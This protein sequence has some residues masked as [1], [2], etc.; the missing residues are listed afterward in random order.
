MRGSGTVKCRSSFLRFA[1]EIGAAQ[2]H[3]LGK[4]KASNSGGRGAEPPLRTSQ[5]QRYPIGSRIVLDE[6]NDPY[7]CMPTGLRGV[8][9]GVDN[10]GNIL[11]Q[12]D[13][14]STLNVVPDVDKAHVVACD[15][16][17]KIS[18]E[19]C[20]SQKKTNIFPRC[21]EQITS[22]NRLLALSRRASITI[23]E[24]CGSSEALED[25]GFMKKKPIAEWA[26]VKKQ[27]VTVKLLLT[28]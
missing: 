6:M 16:E 15:E 11:V 21:G 24:L 14:G 26:V 18:L 9:Q 20:E 2:Y 8:C 5:I 23:C 27:L 19:W 25:A 17:I 22:T 1:Q 7:C 10:A 13:N 4:T 12:W 28:I 3:S